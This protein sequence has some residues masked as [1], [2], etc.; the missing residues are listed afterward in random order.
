MDNN[1]LLAAL[2]MDAVAA[3]R[4]YRSAVIA[5][6]GRRG[7]R[8]AGG[9]RSGP[10]WSRGFD[11]LD[12]RLTVRHA[13]MADLAGRLLGWSAAS[14]WWSRGPDPGG[15]VRFYAGPKAH[16]LHLV[17]TPPEVVDWA[18]AGLTGRWNNPGP[19]HGVDL[20]DDPAALHRLIG[21]VDAQRRLHATRAVRAPSRR[22]MTPL[23]P[24]RP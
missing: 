11:P 16:P 3:V 5:D 8:L 20:E 1:A 19:P 7:L 9:S 23:S 13:G 4:G 22:P 14:G 2:G 10:V 17:P 12:I 18:C 15:P 24:R 21:F 6:A